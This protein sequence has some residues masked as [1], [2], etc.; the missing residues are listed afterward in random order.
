MDLFSARE[1]ERRRRRD[2]KGQK[3]AR[4]RPACRPPLFSL[5]FLE[6]GLI[7]LGAARSS[8]QFYGRSCDA[9]C[10][11]PARL[12]MDGCLPFFLQNSLGFPAEAQTLFLRPPRFYFLFCA[13][14]F[15]FICAV[16]RSFSR[17]H[18]ARASELEEKMTCSSVFWM[19]AGRVREWEADAGWKFTGVLTKKLTCTRTLC[20][21]KRSKVLCY[22]I[23]CNS[24]KVKCW[25]FHF[26]P[27]AV[28]DKENK[29]E[30]T[31]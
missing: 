15:L 13:H 27:R 5:H 31:F 7:D 1:R 21:E 30:L 23:A 2:E 12:Q 3:Y 9:C 28:L 25:F 17:K 14:I 10:C 6:K 20:S 29:R 19:G 24:R 11:P 18:N 22:G 4:G 26:W 16:R 8:M